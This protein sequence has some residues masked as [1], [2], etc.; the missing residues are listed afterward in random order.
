MLYKPLISLVMAFAAASSVAASVAP[1]ARD[2]YAPS[3]VPTIPPKQCQGHVKCCQSLSTHAD[4][5]LK[6]LGGFGSVPTPDP[7]VFGTGCADLDIN[8][9]S[10]WYR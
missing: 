6:G 7:D 10:Q 2:G 9:F 3:N 8:N 1:V 5:N 4:P